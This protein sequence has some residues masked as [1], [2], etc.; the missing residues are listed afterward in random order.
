MP[1]IG[2]L[3]YGDRQQNQYI[4]S[5]SS[6]NSFYYA[7]FNKQPSY[8]A[9]NWLINSLTIPKRASWDRCRLMLVPMLVLMT[10][11]RL[12]IV[13]WRYL[14]SKV[15]YPTLATIE[16]LIERIRHEAD[17][18]RR[19]PDFVR[20]AVRDMVRRVNVCLDRNV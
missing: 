19:D 4:N 15:Y 17:E 5:L 18:L 10:K 6:I 9:I 7:V 2:V 13:L 16:Q 11:L 1:L 20:E 8:H 12:I 14:K 3:K